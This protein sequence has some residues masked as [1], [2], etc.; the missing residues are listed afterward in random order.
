MFGNMY[1]NAEGIFTLPSV[2][3][4]TDSVVLAG[5]GGGLRAKI[6]HTAYFNQYLEPNGSNYPAT[7]YK[8]CGA[9]AAVIAISKF[10]KPIT[11]TD[12]HAYKQYMYKD[13]FIDKNSPTCGSNQGGAFQLTNV[14]CSMSYAGG[15]QKY[16][17]A[18]G[19]HSTSTTNISFAFVKSAIDKGHPI[20]FGMTDSNDRSF[21]HIATIVGYTYSNDIV[22]Q[23][24]YT[25]VQGLGRGWKSYYTGNLV[26][27]NLF[28][29][30]WPINYL[31]EVY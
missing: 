31:I 7:G 5:E 2:T 27:Y 16:I 19:L 15:I 21:G 1:V 10:N 17:T 9:A 28:S 30:R 14:N 26:V 20:I 3:P 12:D 4:A 29:S 18:Y 23:D 8:M 25:N 11:S 24:T 13:S 6:I 22:V